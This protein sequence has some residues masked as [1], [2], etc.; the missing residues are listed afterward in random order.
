MKKQYSNLNAPSYHG[1]VDEEVIS[2]ADFVQ[3]SDEGGGN[4]LFR[5]DGDV[6]FEHF[7]QQGVVDGEI[8]EKLFV[9]SHG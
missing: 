7:A 2:L 9:H 1:D 5:L 4:F 8:F 6:G 3:D